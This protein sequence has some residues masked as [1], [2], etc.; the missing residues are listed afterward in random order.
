[1]AGVSTWRTRRG[2]ERRFDA[3]GPTAH[4]PAGSRLPQSSDP[5]GVA[6]SARD[7]ARRRGVRRS[8]SKPFQVP[9]FE[10]KFLT[11]FK[12]NCTKV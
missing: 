2:S 8:S 12:Q 9:Y 7:A 6:V 3:S 1:M 5:R 4:R 10:M 11:L